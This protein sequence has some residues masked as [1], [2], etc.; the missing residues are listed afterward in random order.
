MIQD[1]LTVPSQAMFSSIIQ[2]NYFVDIH[3]IY[4]FHR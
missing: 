4:L 3:E 2:H 1:I